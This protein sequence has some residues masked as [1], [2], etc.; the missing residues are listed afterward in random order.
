MEMQHN[1]NEAMRQ[2]LNSHTFV[3]YANFFI[4][5]HTLHCGSVHRRLHNKENK[6]FQTVWAV[7]AI[8]FWYFVKKIVWKM[9][10]YAFHRPN[11]VLFL[12]KEHGKENNLASDPICLWL[13]SLYGCWL[14][15]LYAYQ[16][17]FFF[18]KPVIISQIQ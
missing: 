13:M 12:Y 1:N 6:L 14:Q 17:V 2:K 9:T 5:R 8:V 11:Y 15:I 18:Q 4:T 3:D 16:Q 7:F 10:V